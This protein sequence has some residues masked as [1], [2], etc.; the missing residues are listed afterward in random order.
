MVCSEK[1]GIDHS[2]SLKVTDA[3]TKVTIESCLVLGGNLSSASL[4][5][6]SIIP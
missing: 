2:P 4:Q 1:R 5:A 6:F 3:N